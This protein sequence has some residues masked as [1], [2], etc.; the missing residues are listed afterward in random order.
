MNRVANIIKQVA[1]HDSIERYTKLGVECL[2]G[3]A[4]ITSPYSISINDQTVTTRS[5]VIATGARPLV[6]PIPG[7]ED[8][9]YYTSDTIWS[10]QQHPKRML[11]LGGG[12]IGCEL[13]QSFAR[14]NCQVI[15][16][17][18]ADKIMGREDNEI[19]DFMAQQFQNEG[20]DL[21]LS[22]EAKKFITV[23]DE[24]MLICDHNGQEVSIPFDVVL[25]G[26]RSH[27]LCQ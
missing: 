18:R 13:A 19:S 11:I 20:I 6:P 8:I 5:I 4:Q 16:V 24:K 23:N 17:E 14:M 7:L 1:P 2:Q 10:L 22:H 15:Q 3:R 9:D 27:C 12:P 25:I 26:P 21:K